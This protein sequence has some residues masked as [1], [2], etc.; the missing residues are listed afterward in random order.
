[1]R[2]KICGVCRPE[3]A[4]LAAEAGADYI[5]VILAPGGKRSQTEAA[6]AEIYAAAPGCRRVGV[7]VDPR[8]EDVA[9][10][11]TRLSLDVVQLHGSERPEGVETLRG[12]GWEVWK[13]IRPRSAAQFL[14]GIERYAWAADALLLDG[15]SP[16]A[17]GGTGARFPWDEVAEVRDRL[18]STLRL[19]VAG[20][21][22]PG[23]LADVI[24]RLA[25]DVVD[26]SSGV[27]SAIGVKDPILVREFVVAARAART[28][29]GG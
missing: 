18:P 20:G 11:A 2:V 9:A 27:E 13:A 25:P 10:L 17:P 28:D 1:M 24:A 21:L 15:W 16:S 7:F 22:E 8:I 4:V 6:A 12:R 26:V 3:D 14:L 23:N 19:V 5:G 29:S